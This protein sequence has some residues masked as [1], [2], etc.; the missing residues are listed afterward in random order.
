MTASLWGDVGP[1]FWV[2]GVLGVWVLV[3]E[4]HLSHKGAECWGHLFVERR[5]LPWHQSL[6][7]ADEWSGQGRGVPALGTP[8]SPC[9]CLLGAGCS[10]CPTLWQLLGWVGQPMK[11]NK[12]ALV[13]RVQGKLGG[14]AFLRGMT[15]EGNSQQSWAGAVRI[16]GQILKLQ[17]MHIF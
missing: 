16:Q 11:P 5:A 7:Q 14:F 2:L 3:A 17:K 12:W 9:S 4:E 10:C 13:F 15:P 6:V 1:G 8:V